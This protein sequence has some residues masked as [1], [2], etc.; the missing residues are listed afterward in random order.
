MRVYNFLSATNALDNLAKRRMK[1]CMLNG[2]NDP[3]D[4]TAADTLDPVVEEAV[5]AL[6]E[7]F[8]N[9]SLLCFSK[10]WDN[11]LM[12]SHYG[13]SHTGNCLGF[14]IPDTQPEGGFQLRVVYRNS[15]LKVQDA[16]E[17]NEKFFNELL[18]TKYDAWSYEQEVRLFVEIKDLPG[19]K[20][21]HWFSF[22]D[23]LNLKEI[24]VGARCSP[25]D[26]KKLRQMCTHDPDVVDVSW[27]S[28]KKDAF[29][30]FRSECRPPGG[31]DLVGFLLGF[32][33]R[34]VGHC[35]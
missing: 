19:D 15:L 29:S 20:G 4:L 9:K 2:L 14:D 7:S 6:I 10:K 32:A 22:G 18:R 11:I 3:F 8:H 1:I 13:C 17:I 24:I 31:N 34:V 35:G 28:M 21:M 23:T 12:W 33:D 27:V 5:D 16:A 26:A 25:E 30:L